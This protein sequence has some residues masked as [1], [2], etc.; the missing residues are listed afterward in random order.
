MRRSTLFAVASLLLASAAH[1]QAPARN[2][3]FFIGDGMGPA[4]VDSAR[5]FKGCATATMALD[6]FPIYGRART[7]STDDFVTDSAAAG[8]ALATG[9]KTY[10]A[11]IGK[12]D[13]GLDPSGDGR[14]LQTLV[15]IARDAGKAV[16]VVSTARITHATPASFYAHVL[17]RDDESSIA[18]QLKDSGLAV[19]LGG[20]REFFHGVN[21]QD[22][23]STATGKRADNRDIVDELTRA[24]WIAVQSRDELMKLDPAS[25]GGPVLGL[26]QTGHMQYELD[27]PGDK[28][29]EPS[30]AE[31][32]EFAIR[33]LQTDSDGWFLMVEAGRIDHAS[34]SNDAAR[35]VTDTLAL[36]EAV[37]RAVE[38]AGDDTLIVV[39]ADHE[40]GAVT[41][42][43]HATL[44][45][46]QGE[47][48]LEAIGWGS[49]GHSAVSVP[50]FARGPG[51]RGFT[52]TLQNS[53]IARLIARAMRLEFNAPANVENYAA[54]DKLYGPSLPARPRR[55]GATA[56][57]GVR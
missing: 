50:I 34:H 43:G 33:A 21:W 4:H 17:K 25:P 41:L 29:G 26:F 5:L 8:T 40:T 24:G 1:A 53:A 13:P 39:T 27:R 48:V 7:Y 12:S 16:G 19:A 31:L 49:K 51:A 37:A 20:G 11:G 38:L 2:V 55:S 57:A 42:N 56:A 52:G 44:D 6:E 54:Q 22:P 14:D 32:T 23:E 46:M 28:L 30:L 36:D 15:D 47:R 18:E 45:E 10:N 35:M 3:I 9:V